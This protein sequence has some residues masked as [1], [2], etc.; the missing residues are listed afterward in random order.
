M[1][2]LGV[3]LVY[4]QELEPLFA[5]GRELVQVLELEAQTL[6]EK[7]GRRGALE[8]RVN[9]GLLERIAA[10]P[11][12][13]LVHGVGHPLGGLVDDPID[14]TS[15]F[16][17]CT[18]MLAPAWAS[19][20]LS[21]NRYRPDHGAVG[22][23]ATVAET[24][25][26]LPP[27]QTEAGVAIAARNVRRLREV[28]GVPVAFETGVN[29]LRP[30]TDELPDGHYFAAI[31]EHADC[32]I[33]LDL[34]N[35]WANE[36]NGRMPLREVLATLPLERIWELHLAGG[37][38]LDGYWLDAHDGLVDPELHE[39][40][41]E[42]I[43]RLPNL[44]AINFEILP[45]YVERTGID[46]IARQLEHLQDL[47]ALRRPLHVIAPPHDSL[48]AVPPA[49]PSWPDAAALLDV[50]RWERSLGALALGL[51]PPADA[52]PGMDAAG[53]AIFEQL[54]R[55]FRAGRIVR[56]LRYSLLLLLRELGAAR[57]DALIRAYCR[58][59]PSD[60]FTAVEAERFAEF[61]RG[62]LVDGSLALPLLDEVLAFERAMI[63]AS[64]WGRDAT[65]HWSV[66]PV[67]L[68]ERIEAGEPL[69]TLARMPL[70]MQ[71]EGLGA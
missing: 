69:T 20:H 66:D 35:L 40:A 71:V 11:Q 47:W 16:A 61:L 46:R 67:Q 39:L 49:A 45:Q 42:V 7:S 58:A 17:H 22:D 37:S 55:E 29:Y 60:I 12:A 24:S 62:K 14:W 68:L 5:A 44:G 25:F 63:A 53:G 23:A 8:Y 65:L 10:L 70:E 59:C 33:L 54:V 27:R 51:P 13:K 52:L 38:A 56:V 50:Q 19:E 41:A 30:R 3:G 18:T 57:V 28:A 1:Q 31:A 64:L 26:L 15:A 2:A 4:W 32:G 36:R 48:H 21:F 6:W 34:H 43:P 9:D